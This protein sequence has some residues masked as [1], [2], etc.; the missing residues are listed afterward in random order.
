MNVM[1]VN[2][3][4]LRGELDRKGLFPHLEDLASAP[5]VFRLDFGLG[6]LPEKPGFL[7]VRGPRQ[8]GKSTWLEREMKWTIEVHGPGSALYLNGDHLADA[9]ALAADLRRGAERLPGRKGRLERTW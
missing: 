8:Y 3:C 1:D 5:F 7:A 6:D 4:L 9:D 2:D